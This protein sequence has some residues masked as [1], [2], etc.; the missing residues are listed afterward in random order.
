MLTP[1]DDSL[2]RDLGILQSNESQNYNVGVVLNLVRRFLRL[3]LTSSESVDHLREEFLDFFY[4]W[5]LSHYTLTKPQSQASVLQMMLCAGSFLVES[6]Q[7]EDC[8]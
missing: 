8:K 4:H 6:W 5:T 2:L 1:F 3:R 7:D